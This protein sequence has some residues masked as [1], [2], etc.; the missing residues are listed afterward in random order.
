MHIIIKNAVKAHIFKADFPL[1][2]AKLLLNRSEQPFPRIAEIEQLALGITQR[3]NFS[4]DLHFHMAADSFRG[5][6]LGIRLVQRD[7]IKKC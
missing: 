1:R 6:V 2:P 5:I 7:I 3:A 4:R